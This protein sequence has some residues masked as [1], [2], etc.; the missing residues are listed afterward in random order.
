MFA[1]DMPCSGTPPHPVLRVA[2]GVGC[3][4]APALDCS[5][6]LNTMMP[7][8]VVSSGKLSLLALTWC[9]CFH[10]DREE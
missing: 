1:Q 5:L 6:K 8:E 9:L 2:R 4:T 3:L 10:L 7:I